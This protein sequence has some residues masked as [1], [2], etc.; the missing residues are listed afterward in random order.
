MCLYKNPH[1]TGFQISKRCSEFKEANSKI[2]E[3]L[4][5]SKVGLAQK[6]RVILCS[7]FVRTRH[8]EPLDSTELRTRGGKLR[9][10][11]AICF[12]RRVSICHMHAQLCGNHRQFVEAPIPDIEEASALSRHVS[13]C[14]MLAQLYENH[15]QSVEDFW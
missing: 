6:P 11:R 7:R 13:I 8:M 5:F 1:S 3:A 14:H 4:A 15:G 2:E 12:S 9:N 10:Q